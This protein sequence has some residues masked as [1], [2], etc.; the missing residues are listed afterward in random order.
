MKNFPRRDFTLGFATIF[1]GALAGAYFFPREVSNIGIYDKDEDG[2]VDVIEDKNW[3]IVLTNNSSYLIPVKD[4]DPNVK[5]CYF[6]ESI[7]MENIG[8]EFAQRTRSL[9][10]ECLKKN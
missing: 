10:E 9:L 5:I 1:A 7:S 8:Q 2:Y 4:L 6:S 3:G